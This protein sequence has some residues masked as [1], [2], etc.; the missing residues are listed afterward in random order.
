M[1]NWCIQC[2]SFASLCLPAVSECGFA[3]MK[4]RTVISISFIGV[5]GGTSVEV[6]GYCSVSA[7]GDGIEMTLESIN[8]TIFSLPDILYTTLRKLLEQRMRYRRFELWQEML[9][10][11]EIFPSR[12]VANESATD[13]Q[14][15]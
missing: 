10:L 11:L 5:T 4:S 6:S 9:I 2:F 12:R 13:V 7:R 14:A 3:L 15:G 8:D 1:C